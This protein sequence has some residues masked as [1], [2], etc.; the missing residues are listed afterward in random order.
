[1]ERRFQG[2]ESSME[3]KFLEHSLLKSESSTGAKVPWNESSWTFHS[4]GANVPWN[5]SSTGAKVLSM[6]FSLPGTKVQRNKKASY[7]TDEARISSGIWYTVFVFTTI[8]RNDIR[9]DPR[10]LLVPIVV[11]SVAPRSKTSHRTSHFTTS[12]FTPALSYHSIPRSDYT[13]LEPCTYW[14]EQEL[15]N[16]FE[17]K[18]INECC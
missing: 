6:V 9:V 3:R 5:E 2:C 10:T 17:Y 12:Q 4:P 1:M 7:R 8:R 13:R 14:A 15:Y 18:K 16:M 11:L